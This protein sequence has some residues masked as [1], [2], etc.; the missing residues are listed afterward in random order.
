MHQLL[1]PELGGEWVLL[2][3]KDIK[4]LLAILFVFTAREVYELTEEQI[5]NFI[6]QKR[7]AIDNYLIR[8][9]LSDPSGEIPDDA[10]D[11]DSGNSKVNLPNEADMV[12]VGVE[13]LFNK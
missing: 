11:E 6:D 12:G 3:N 8:E 1:S 13:A 9:I 10:I 5:I 4:P 2:N 7:L